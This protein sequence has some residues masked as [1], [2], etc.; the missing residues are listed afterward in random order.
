MQSHTWAQYA[1]SDASKSKVHNDLVM[2]Q[3]IIGTYGI[4]KAWTLIGAII[5]YPSIFV[6]VQIKI[7]CHFRNFRRILTI[8]KFDADMDKHAK[9]KG[10]HLLIYLSI[11]LF[12]VTL[13]LWGATY[14]MRFL[15]WSA[16]LCNGFHNISSAS[17]HVGNIVSIRAHNCQKWKIRFFTCHCYKTYGVLKRSWT[18]SFLLYFWNYTFCE[19]V[20]L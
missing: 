11:Y 19:Y 3:L 2:S 16:V 9:V 10:L 14:E 17:N 8:T 1:A 7:N 5:R 15:V 18:I 12:I 6:I 13:S 20:K 4:G